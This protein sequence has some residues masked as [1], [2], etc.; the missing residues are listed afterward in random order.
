MEFPEKS[1]FYKSV[2]KVTS[3]RLGSSP[4][5][6]S[7]LITSVGNVLSAGK[8]EKSPQSKYWSL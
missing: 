4:A 1:C 2:V 6:K 5:A 8:P 7:K 3:V